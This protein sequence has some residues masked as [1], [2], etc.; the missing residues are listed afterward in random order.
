MR[1]LTGFLN[2]YD[3]KKIL[4][5]GTGNGNFIKMIASMTNDFEEIVGI[6]EIEVA[7]STS[8]K[9]FE[10]E[11]IRFQLMSGYKMEF[12]DDTFDMVCLSNTL[13]HLDDIKGLFKEMERVVV[14]GGVILINEMIAN[15]LSK[16]Q[17]SHLKIHHFAAEIDRACGDIHYETM[18][19]TDVLKTLTDNS[20][21]EIRDA[22]NL[23]F[24][25]PAD[26]TKEEI[27]WLISTIDRLLK[28]MEDKDNYQDYVKQGEKIK[29]Y[30][31]KNGF[32]SATQLV[33]VL[34]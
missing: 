25:R 26:N 6:D 24:E 10:D 16:R 30:I 13:H 31:K 4:D 1:K 8:Q 9:N 11:R 34:S 17:K 2:H 19:A 7:I 5:V 14:P 29:K 33:V 32:D 27:D 28:K 3:F 15:G 12:E 23:T 18:V 20:E 22:W 21:L